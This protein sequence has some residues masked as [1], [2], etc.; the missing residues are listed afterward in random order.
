MRLQHVEKPASLLFFFFFR[1]TFFLLVVDFPDAS[2]PAARAFICVSR[3]ASMRR[4]SSFVA[5]GARSSSGPGGAGFEYDMGS[6]T[7]G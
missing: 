2:L 7:E 4:K 1:D 3:S 6:G 5:S